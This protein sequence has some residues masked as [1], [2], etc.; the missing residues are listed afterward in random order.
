MAQNGALGAAGRVQFRLVRPGE[1]SGSVLG[2]SEV[3]RYGLPRRGLTREMAA[4]RRRNISNVM[5]GFKD[6]MAARYARVPTLF[7]ALWV[8]KIGADGLLVDYGLASLRL[9]TNAGVNYLVDALQN[10]VE[11][12][13]LKFHALGTGTTAE[14]ATD[15]ALVTEWSSAE[16]S[17]GVRA[18]GS[19]A[20]GA[21]AN[22]F[23]TVG[24]NTKANAGTSAVTEH[25]ILSQAALG[26]GTLLDRSV[27]SAINLAQ[28]DALQTTYDLTLSS[29]G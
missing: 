18:T 28:N 7:G 21:S 9:V 22:I 27:F 25:G 13:N 24:T 16:Y 29:G 15:T 23:K 10:L 19:L 14:A 5:R 3:V 6:L 2:V 17:G 12:E 20:E 4:W 11:A 26:G 8:V 1:L